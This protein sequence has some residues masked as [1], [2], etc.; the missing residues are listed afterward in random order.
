MPRGAIA[1]TRGRALLIALTDYQGA[2]AAWLAGQDPFA[3]AHV[4]TR[5]VQSSAEKAVSA[6]RQFGVTVTGAASDGG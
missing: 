1:I 2:L 4:Q 3:G 5:G 6:A